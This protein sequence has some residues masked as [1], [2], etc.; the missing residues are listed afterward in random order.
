M[1]EQ[2]QGE[3]PEERRPSQ[4]MMKE[5]DFQK[6]VDIDDKNLGNVD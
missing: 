4:G 5:R 6:M 2:M 3:Q 1:M